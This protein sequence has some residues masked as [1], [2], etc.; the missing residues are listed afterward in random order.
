MPLVERE[1]VPDIRMLADQLMIDLAAENDDHGFLDALSTFEAWE[2]RMTEL[3]DYKRLAI[4]LAGRATHLTEQ[5]RI[6]GDEAG[7]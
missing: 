7:L 3:D 5:L 2:A 6:L 4:E 1:D